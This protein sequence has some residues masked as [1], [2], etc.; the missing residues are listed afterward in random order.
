MAHSLS[1]S[2]VIDKPIE[3]VFDFLAAR[4]NDP[5]FEAHGFGKVF[6][7]LAARAAQQDAPAFAGRIKA[8]AEAT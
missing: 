2:T 5:T 8:A 4:V 1:G 6:V 3:E 7:G